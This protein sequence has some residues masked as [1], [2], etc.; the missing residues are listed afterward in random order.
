MCNHGMWFPVLAKIAQ[1]IFSVCASSTPSEAQFSKA[2][3][4]ANPWHICLGYKATQ[5]TLCFKAWYVMPELRDFEF[6][7]Q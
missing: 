4:V 6:L 1:D 7:G 2:G 5:A 3:K